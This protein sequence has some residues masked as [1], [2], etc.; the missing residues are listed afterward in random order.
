MALLRAMCDNHLVF[1][2]THKCG[3]NDPDTRPSL[4]RIHD[5]DPREFVAKFYTWHISML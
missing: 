5:L 2:V 4:S 3:T 1:M